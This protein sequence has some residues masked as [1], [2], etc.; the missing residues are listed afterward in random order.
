MNPVFKI[1]KFWE[2]F[3]NLEYPEITDNEIQIHGKML[4]ENFAVNWER[5]DG[6]TYVTVSFYFNCG[7][8]Y[9][10]LLEYSPDISGCSKELY[11]V[12]KSNKANIKTHNM[13]WWD[14][15]RW[16]PYCLRMEEL[17]LLLKY[18]KTYDAIWQNPSY[19]MSNNDGK[20]NDDSWAF[21]LL[22][23]A[24]FVGVSD[25]AT[26]IILE[27]SLY[28]HLKHL[29][30]NTNDKRLEELASVHQMNDYKWVENKEFGWFFEGDDYDCYS[31][32]NQSHFGGNEGTFP[33]KEWNAMLAE[34][35]I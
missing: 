9:D 8:N 16:H 21:P 25:D 19:S 7:D 31:L 33:Y 5:E 17:D 18:W 23:M 35:E 1:Q 34:I 22:L 32:R 11:L 28:N 29:L 2:L 26:R 14:L 15:A 30:P 24:S 6:E 13:G 4:E 20:N 12:D 3:I 27:D 10:L